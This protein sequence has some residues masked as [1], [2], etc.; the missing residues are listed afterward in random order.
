M[1]EF[2][3]KEFLAH[4]GIKGQ[5]WGVSNGPPYP[6]KSG[7]KSYSEKKASKK[8]SVKDEITKKVSKAKAAIKQKTEEVKGKYTQK[9]QASLTEYL[10]DHPKKIVKYKR[11]LTDA[12]AKKIIDRIEFDRKL[13]DIRD[14]EIQRGRDRFKS[15]VAHT[16]EIKNLLIN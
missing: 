16:Q 12:E 8:K 15:K 11:I 13:E 14:S 7:Q 3:T 5:K 10:R 9:R 2:D 4:H 6:L 1:A